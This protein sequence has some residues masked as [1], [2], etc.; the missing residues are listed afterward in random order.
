MFSQDSILVS[1]PGCI[2]KPAKPAVP[3]TTPKTPITNDIH[4]NHFFLV[5]AVTASIA[6]DIESA[7][8]EANARDIDPA[9]PDLFVC[10]PFVSILRLEG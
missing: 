5:R 4:S 10:T 8:S 7:A 6:I 9:V 1:H 3:I 2:L